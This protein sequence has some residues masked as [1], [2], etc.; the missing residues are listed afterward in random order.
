MLRWLVLHNVR[1][2]SIRSSVIWTQVRGTPLLIFGICLIGQTLTNMDQS[3]FSYAIP[4]MMAEFDVGLE[5]IGW[6]L[7]VSFFFAAILTVIIGIAADRFGRRMMFV[8]CLALSALLVGIHSLAPTIIALTIMRAVAFGLSGAILPLANAFT[9]EAAPAR[10]RGIM[11]T[12]LQS[13]YALGWFIAAIVGVPLLQAFGWRYIFLPALVVVPLAF[14][15][16]R[17]LPESARFEKQ[18]A[19]A[20]QEERVW[21]LNAWLAKLKILWE[22]QLRSRTVLCVLAFFF[23]G[24]AYAGTAFY[25]PTFFKEV[26][27]YSEAE[28]AAITGLSYGIG[29]LG[30]VAVA[31]IGEFFMT[32]RNTIVIWLAIGTA[33]FLGL[34]WI[35]STYGENVF[36]FGL[37]T[38]FFYAVA[39][40]MWAFA[41]ELFPTRVRATS[42]AII[43]AS[44]LAAFAVYPVGV[45]YAVEFMDWRTAFTWVVFPSAIAATVAAWL[46][47]NI[48]SGLDVDEIA[49]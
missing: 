25:F 26:H 37:M 8:G 13:G 46:L 6:I 39:A 47:P 5:T 40:V 32:R 42:S 45:A 10:V 20:T 38:V 1:S 14:I 17:Y 34:I 23:Q 43:T 18:K 3:L 27:G 21:D 35:P 49:T 19:M 16:A 7:S 41:A 48:K 24:G 44:I 4:G 12:M 28:A 11:T 33:A 22:P 2:R 36:W 15:F 29:F 30:Y 31:I 9:A